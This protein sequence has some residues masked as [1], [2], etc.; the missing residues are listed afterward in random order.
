M[1]DG[2]QKK[3]KR[4]E[5]DKPKQKPQEQPGSQG[6]DNEQS[7]PKSEKHQRTAAEWITLGISAAIILSLIGLITW[8]Y[9]RET[10]NQVLLEV[11]PQME[12]VFTQNG[13]YYL[14]VKLSNV[15]DE[16]AANLWVAL[17]LTGSQGQT[18]TAEINLNF[19]PAHGYHQAD[20]AFTQ[21]PRQGQLD[22][23]FGYVYP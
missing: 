19:I 14:P 20:V 23:T 13:Q 9:F 16:T 1:N 18:E 6:Q 21:D 15:G 4:Q 11:H 5:Q 8:L 2:K 12:A 10:S 7:E 22:I 17:K 3:N